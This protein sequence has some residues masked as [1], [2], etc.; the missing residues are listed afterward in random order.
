MLMCTAQAG[1][2]SHPSLPDWWR[3]VKRPTRQ[4]QLQ[5]PAFS[6]VIAPNMCMASCTPGVLTNGSEGL[7]CDCGICTKCLN[8][9]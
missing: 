3:L 4:K 1:A 7:A 6:P 8:V 9:P 5:Y 2:S